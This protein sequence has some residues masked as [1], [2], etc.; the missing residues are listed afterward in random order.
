MPHCFALFAL[1]IMLF[2]V[3]PTYLHSFN[4]LLIGGVAVHMNSNM[5]LSGKKNP[6]LSKSHKMLIMT[7][8]VFE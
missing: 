6:S 3:L 5:P 4:S 7:L 8:K 1:F 2:T